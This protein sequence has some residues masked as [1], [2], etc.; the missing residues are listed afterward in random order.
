M[1]P[2]DIADDE[3]LYRAVVGPQ[4]DLI[5]GGMLSPALFIDE[6]GLSVD[7]DGNRSE[8]E[9]VSSLRYRFRNAPYH[10]AL[11]L[12]A[13]DCRADETYPVAIGNKRH[14]FHAEIHDSPTVVP[15]SLLKALRLANRAQLLQ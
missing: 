9:V 1:L 2:S 6:K 13:G 3:L 11:R 7:R 4:F 15:I 5:E 10:A 14:I 12:K 8:Q